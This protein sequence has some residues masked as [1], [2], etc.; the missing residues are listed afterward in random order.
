MIQLEIDGQNIEVPEGTMLIEAAKKAGQY[1]PHFCYHKKLSIAANCRMC[2]VDVEKAP[3]PLPACATPVTQGMKVFTASQKAKDA[4]KS[5]MEFLL[6]NHPLDCPICDQ[7]GECQ[8]QDLAVGYGGVKSRYQEEKRIVFHKNV[9]PLI[10]MEEMSRCIHCTR[11]VRFGQEIAG[12]MEFGMVGRGEHSEITSFL[13]KTID[14]ELSG[15]MIDICPVGALTSKPFRYSAR[16]WELSRRLSISSHDALGS[17]LMGQVKD[18]KVMRV[19]PHENEAINE[20]WI[21][22]RDRFSYEGVYHNQRLLKPMLKDDQGMWHEVEWIYAFQ[23]FAN[24]IRDVKTQKTNASIAGLFNAQHTNEEIFLFKKLLNG[25]GSDIVDFRLKHSDTHADEYQ[26]CIGLNGLK[27]TDFSNHNDYKQISFIG[28]ALRNDHPLLCARVRQSTKFGTKIHSL[29]ALSAQDW[30]M[31]IASDYVLAPHQWLIFMQQVKAIVCQESIPQLSQSAKHTAMLEQAHKFAQDLIQQG[32]QQI[33]ALGANITYHPHR[34]LIHYTCQLIAEK[35]ACGFVVLPD[36]CNTIGAYELGA[37]TTKSYQR[38]DAYILM[39]VDLAYDINAAQTLK[40]SLNA[41]KTVIA[42]TSYLS[43][44]LLDYADILLPISTSFETSG[45]FINMQGDELSFQG[46]SKSVGESRPAWKILKVMADTLALNGFEYN[47]T[48]DIRAEMQLNVQA[49]IKHKYVQSSTIEPLKSD[50][51]YQ[52]PLNFERVSYQAIYHSDAIVRHSTSLQNTELA[53]K[54]QN[55]YVH[56]NVL[57]S[58]NLKNGDYITLLQG[59]IMVN[60]Q[61]YANN[62]LNEYVVLIPNASE[63]AQKLDS[64]YGEI[65]IE[66]SS[67]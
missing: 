57:Q 8:L 1:V 41:A 61:I 24:K 10:S 11:C 9:G 44:D 66:K 65:A 64:L 58:K 55:I 4:Q 45:S 18:G 29:H 3:K 22:D 54:A 40:A 26:S 59:Q 46:I 35:L 15:N 63:V 20:C 2:L 21:S 52:Q 5:V 37:Y 56:S 47:S 30:L 31:P 27:I 39:G 43:P 49:S 17:H 62:L 7:G 38:A 60:A 48:T 16:T 19:L 53:K 36:S 42:C 51:T 67:D 25:L 32:K 23:T 33:I 13:G 28:S 12:I 6:I 50:K 34:H 14:S